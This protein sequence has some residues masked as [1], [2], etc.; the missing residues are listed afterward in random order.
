M[1]EDKIK[2][3]DFYDVYIQSA[4]EEGARRIIEEAIVEAELLLKK[5]YSK[6]EALKICEALKKKA[7]FIKILAGLFSA[8]IILR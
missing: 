1:P 8:R 6:E 7:G 5:E 4:G 2:I 3:E